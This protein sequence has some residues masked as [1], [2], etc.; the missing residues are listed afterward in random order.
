MNST[1]QT[2]LR[3]EQI[4][5]E[6][7]AGKGLRE[8]E[9]NYVCRCGEIDI[10]ARHRE[11]LVFVEVRYRRSDKYGGGIASVDSKKQRK[12]RNTALYYLQQ[13]G[14][15]NAPCRFDVISISG[16]LDNP[17]LNWIRNAF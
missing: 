16:E 11:H 1:R 2:G 6:F 10:I 8:I 17:S 14:L 12:L 9:H 15:S 4:A 13:N 7:L 3:A 5:R